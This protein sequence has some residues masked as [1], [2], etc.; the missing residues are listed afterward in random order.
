MKTIGLLGG[1]SWESTTSYY[2]AINQGVKAQLGG[3]HSAKLVLLSVDFAEIEALQHQGNWQQTGVILAQAAQAVEAAGADFFL[4]GTNT[5]HKVAPQIEAAVSIPL[6][7]IAD[8]TAEQLTTDGITKVGL[9]GTRFTME[10]DFYR[11]RLT[12]SHG[13]EVLVPNEAQRQVVH[14]I[15]YDELCQGQIRDASR[16][17]YLSIIADLAAQGAEAVI[18]GC[19]EIALL[20]EQ[21]D[22]SVPLY[23]TTAIHSAA[24]VQLALS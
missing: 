7:H 13:I 12:D 5:M 9:L 18:L 17:A 8:A 19:T 1:M 6:L 11:G 10:Q 24:A 15:I 21:S 3:L 14:Q 22:T 16:Q 20:V 23:D 2:T 4:I